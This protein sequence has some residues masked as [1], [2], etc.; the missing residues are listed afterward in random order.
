MSTLTNKTLS[1]NILS[2]V[3]A[4]CDRMVILSHGQIVAE[5]TLQDLQRTFVDKTIFE[6]VTKGNK[7]EIQKQIRKIDQA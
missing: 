6:I 4:C 7:I 3:E 1:G 5:G 2:E